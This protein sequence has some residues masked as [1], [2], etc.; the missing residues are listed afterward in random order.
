MRI[1]I[2]HIGKT[3]KAWLA[4]G[5]DEYLK[6][7]SRYAKVTVQYLKPARTQD[8]NMA[9]KQESDVLRASLSKQPGV[10]TILLDERGVSMTSPKLARHI[11]QLAV[12]G[13]NPIRF[14]TGGA[15]GVDD[16]FRKEADLVLSLSDMVFPHEIARVVLLEQLYRAFTILRGESYH[17]I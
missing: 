13:R 4:K 3:K 9:R 11:E 8:A 7:C 6:K 5:E 15:F 17:H 16:D 12:Q 10:Y 1:E 14:I 2:W